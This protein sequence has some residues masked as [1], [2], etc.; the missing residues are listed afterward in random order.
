MEAI[1][2]DGSNPDDDAP[3]HLTGDHRQS[4]VQIP[5]Y[6]YVEKNKTQA[7]DPIDAS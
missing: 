1:E 7:I 2:R 6:S 3:P 4:P 5:T